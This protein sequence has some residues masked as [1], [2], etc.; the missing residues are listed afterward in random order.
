MANRLILVKAT[1]DNEVRVW[2][3]ESS[4]LPGLNIE[5]D[6]LE[7]LLEKLPAAVLD[8]IEEAGGMDAD[9]PD[10]VG[11]REVPIELVAHLSTRLRIPAAA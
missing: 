11:E 9:E 7:A 10:H 4:A 1:F 6:S 5:A 2:F 8:L 3:V